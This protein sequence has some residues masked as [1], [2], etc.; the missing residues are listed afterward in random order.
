MFFVRVLILFLIVISFIS[1][2][3][4]S[5]KKEA[6]IDV[7]TDTVKFARIFQ[8]NSALGKDAVIESVFPDQNFGSETYFSVFSWTNGG[9]VN[10]ARAL[11]RFDLSEIPSYTSIKSAQ[12]VLYW[13]AYDNLIEHTGENAFVVYRINQSWNENSVTWNSQPTITN[14]DS[15]NVSKSISSNQTY[16]VDVT[17]M[18]QDMIANPVTNYGFMLKLN[19]EFP[20]RLV[21][22]ASSDH[23]DNSK[24]PKLIV[25][26]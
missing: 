7:T 12:L 14:L 26:F 5:C 2:T 20:Y 6:T 4:I 1:I 15:M 23:P 22:L 10:T 25:Y 8:P 13:S 18:V 16:T 17:N 19:E 9:V 11:V 3:S 24:H 21:I